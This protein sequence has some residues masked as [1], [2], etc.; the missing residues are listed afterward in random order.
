MI[1][2]TSDTTYEAESRK[3]DY[4]LRLDTLGRWEVWSRRQALGRMNP[5]TVRH[6]DTLEEVC[7]QIPAF[8]GLTALLA[9]P[10]GTVSLYAI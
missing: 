4:Y 8:Q 1:R 7:D 6:F 9:E 2:K 5:G 10:V 3:V